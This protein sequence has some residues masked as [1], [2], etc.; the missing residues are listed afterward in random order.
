MKNIKLFKFN[1]SQ[2][3]TLD[4]KKIF[5]EIYTKFI[6]GFHFRVKNVNFYDQYSFL[7]QLITIISKENTFYRNNTY[8]PTINKKYIK[9][10]SIK[11]YILS[12]KELAKK[13]QK[14]RLSEVD[15]Q[16]NGGLFKRPPKPLLAPKPTK[17]FNQ[18]R[19]LFR[20]SSPNIPSLETSDNNSTGQIM[21][22]S[23]SPFNKATFFPHDFNERAAQSC[24]KPPPNPL[25][26]KLNSQIS[27]S[28]GNLSVANLQMLET[29]NKNSNLQLSVP[30]LK[31]PL[32]RKKPLLPVKRPP[33]SVSNPKLAEKLNKIK[34]SLEIEEEKPKICQKK[35]LEGIELV[36]DLIKTLKYQVGSSCKKPE[37]CRYF[38]SKESLKL[39]EEEIESTKNNIMKSLIEIDN[40]AKLLY[41]TNISKQESDDQTSKCDSSS[42]ISNKNDKIDIKH[43]KNTSSIPESNELKPILTQ[44]EIPDQNLLLEKNEQNVSETIKVPLS[45]PK[46]LNICVK[47]ENFNKSNV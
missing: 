13:Y 38:G 1:S 44:S 40:I 46:R 45:S 7:Y 34:L 39:V 27:C 17:S 18:P 25:L 41:S 10:I 4:F 8:N 32:T 31:P 19:P 24:L 29:Q 22:V 28:T 20:R 33:L 36:E 37:G 42:F 43:N 11:S 23:Y 9:S 16:E 2:S 5:K 12:S 15:K 30:L 21:G 26:V 14:G 3:I 6:Y 47:Q 35:P